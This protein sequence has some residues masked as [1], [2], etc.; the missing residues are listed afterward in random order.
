MLFTV[1]FVL[2]T[3]ELLSDRS[4]NFEQSSSNLPVGI[5]IE[6]LVKVTRPLHSLW[7]CPLCLV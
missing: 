7:V 6:N 3:E 2:F 5:Q 1:L 4:D